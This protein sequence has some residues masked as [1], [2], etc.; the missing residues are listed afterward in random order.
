MATEEVGALSRDHQWTLIP[1]ENTSLNLPGLST[2]VS[3]SWVYLTNGPNR[4]YEWS[5]G[6]LQLKKRS[7]KE[8]SGI[9]HRSAIVVHG[10]KGLGQENISEKTLS[11]L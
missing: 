4:L 6:V 3:D 11:K 1:D 7:I 2:Q 8:T 10:L 9:S 5:W